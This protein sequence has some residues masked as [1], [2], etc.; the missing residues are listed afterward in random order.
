M[1]QPVDFSQINIETPILENIAAEYQD[2]KNR[3]NFLLS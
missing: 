1:Q 3:Q 2:I